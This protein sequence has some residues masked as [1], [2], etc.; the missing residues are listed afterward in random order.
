MTQASTFKNIYWL[1]K[2]CFGVLCPSCY[3]ALRSS[4][5]GSYQDDNKLKHKGELILEMKSK[6]LLI[7]PLLSIVS[8]TFLGFRSDIVLWQI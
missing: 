3:H 4:I 7:S 2:N 1:E 8:L 6:I 5:F